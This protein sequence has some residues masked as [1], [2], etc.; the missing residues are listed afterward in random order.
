MGSFEPTRSEVDA[1]VVRRA[2][3]VVVDDPATAAEHAGPVVDALRDRLLARADLIGLGHVLTGARSA[4]TA[5]DDVVF[6][7]SVGLGVQDAAASWGV[8]HAARGA[9]R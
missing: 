5:P 1:E 9:G 2:K 7:N 8:D 6:Y 4:R 3:A